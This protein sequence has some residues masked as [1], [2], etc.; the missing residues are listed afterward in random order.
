MKAPTK[1][2]GIVQDTIIVLESFLEVVERGDPVL[3]FRK[4]QISRT[5]GQ[6]WEP[7][8]WVSKLE[9]C[10]DKLYKSTEEVT[11]KEE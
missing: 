5:N 9:E 7:S 2:S 10:V 11:K 4:G 8:D 3:L 6:S 1:S